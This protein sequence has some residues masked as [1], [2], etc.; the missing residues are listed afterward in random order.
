[1]RPLNSGPFKVALP[2]INNSHTL[3]RFVIHSL[4]ENST[5]AYARVSIFT[6][7]QTVRVKIYGENH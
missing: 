6:S 7:V 1:M 2:L 5:Y 3:K 4:Y